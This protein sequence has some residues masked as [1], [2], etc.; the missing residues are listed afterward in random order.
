LRD[1]G[2]NHHLNVEDHR[3]VLRA[4]GS[5]TIRTFMN[6]PPVAQPADDRSFESGCRWRVA[7]RAHQALVF[8]LAGASSYIPHFYFDEED[9]RPILWQFADDPDSWRYMEFERVGPEDGL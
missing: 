3:I 7:D 1:V 2:V 5:C 4:D 8:E 6:L 9:G